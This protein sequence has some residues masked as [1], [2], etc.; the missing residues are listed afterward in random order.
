MVSVLIDLRTTIGRHQLQR[1][2]S[3]ALWAGLALG[4]LAALGTLALGVLHGQTVTGA[5]DA[6]SAVLALWFGGQLVQAAVNG[7]ESALRPELLALLPLPRRRLAWALLVVG[8]CDPALAF[9][10][11]AY[12]AVIAVAVG[13]SVAAGLLAA[14]GISCLLVLTGVGAV[15][16]GGILGPGARRGRDLGTILVAVAISVLAVAGA[17]LPTVLSALRDG[18]WSALAAIVRWL[19][20]GW[21]SDGVAAAHRGDWVIA[22]GLMLAP[23]GLAGLLGLA[24]PLIL[25][26]RMTISGPT[27]RG[28][29]RAIHRR[30]LPTTPTGAVAAKEI[31]LWLRDPVRVTCL[32]VAL[33]VG[34]GVGLVP[35]LVG[36][37][38][39]LMP[40]AGPLT[41]LIA[42]ACACNLY[43]S[44]GTSLWLTILTPDAARADVRGR[45]LGWLA[46]VAP[47]AMVETVGLT[48]WSG[49][50]A[51]WPW[52]AA[53]VIALTGGA[54]GLGPL[55]SLISVQP[56]DDGGNPT[57]AFSLKINLALY[58]V[59][60][61][62]LP[63]AGLLVL[64][65][66]GGWPLVSWLAVA[67][68][69][70]T[71]AIAVVGLGS[72]ATRRLQT[73]A[74]RVLGV[75]VAGG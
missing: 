59:L 51:L 73:R 54:A 22:V 52:A 7:G 58:A 42:G 68:A 34:A 3:W 18:R 17:L 75:L 55:A 40:F 1:T 57:P 44:D 43:G 66:L 15:V 60:V 63:S 20:S 4:L 28:P 48:A 31:R 56:L 65:A 6:V 36:G 74:V 62:A 25:G 2:S 61:T 50:Q 23:L 13:I 5:L 71:A 38:P 47:L 27:G 30:R 16:V 32:L 24:W 69:G 64:G 11:L 14:G 53:L 33:I 45:Q 10:A 49:E 19:P 35:E 12:A 39:L 46:L 8:L 37:T 72:I 9:V 70:V 41:V 29:G 21:P 67:V 26:R